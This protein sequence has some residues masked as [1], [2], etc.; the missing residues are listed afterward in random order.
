MNQQDYSYIKTNYDSL[1]ENVQNICLTVGR[2]PGSA[3]IISVSKTF[4]LPVL[5]SAIDQG[6][7]LLGENKVQEAQEKI[8]YL[9][10]HFECHMIGHLQSNKAKHAVNLFDCIHTIDKVSTAQ[11]AGAEA[12]KAGK[13]QD[14]LVQINSSGEDQKSGLIPENA[15][16]V[17]AR[18]ND[19]PGIRLL[20]LMTMARN[21]SDE[22]DIRKSFRLTANLLRQINSELGLSLKELS[23]GMSADYPIALEEGATMIRVGSRIFGAR[24][25]TL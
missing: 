22:D 11:K 20:G 2:D 13:V 15:I 12:L 4:P 8:P 10:G 18:I 21:T 7:L 3:K 17:V 9:K 25:Y 14:I 1:V 16:E 24:E 23:M 5:Q 19:L 6:I